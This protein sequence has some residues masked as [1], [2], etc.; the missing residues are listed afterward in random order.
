MTTKELI[1]FLI[2]KTTAWFLRQAPKVLS[3]EIM[4]NYLEHRNIEIYVHFRQRK[5]VFN[6]KYLSL[7]YLPL[8]KALK[9]QN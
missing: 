8:K 6:Y 2:E 1:Y 4:Y 9:K 7:T 5:H 3:V